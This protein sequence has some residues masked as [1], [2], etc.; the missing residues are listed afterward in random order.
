MALINLLGTIAMPMMEKSLIAGSMKEILG[1]I[2]ALI[3][4]GAI[5]IC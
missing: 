4:H 3:N 1:V 2:W 5:A